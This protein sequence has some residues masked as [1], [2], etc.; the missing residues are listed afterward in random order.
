MVGRPQ[1]SRVTPARGNRRTRVFLGH[2]N[3][4]F[5]LA[6]RAGSARFPITDISILRTLSFS[7]PPPLEPSSRAALSKAAQQMLIIRKEEQY[8]GLIIRN[9]SKSRSVSY[10]WTIIV[11]RRHHESF[12]SENSSELASSSASVETE[13]RSRLFSPCGGGSC[14]SSLSPT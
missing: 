3:G 4:I 8:F 7:V 9:R 14:F 12:T 10:V 1:R 11:Q 5:M 13:G 2:L 6:S